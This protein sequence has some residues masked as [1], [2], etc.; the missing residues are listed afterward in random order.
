M[1][2]GPLSQTLFISPPAGED[3][4]VLGPLAFALIPMRDEL[5]KEW[6]EGPAFVAFYVGP[7]SPCYAVPI[8]FG[9][10][11]HQLFCGDAH[12]LPTH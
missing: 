10:S 3:G 6:P 1:R 7:R 5:R 8:L 9:E 11:P 2:P 4:S 12:G